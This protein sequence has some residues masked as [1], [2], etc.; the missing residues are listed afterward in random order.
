MCHQ[1]PS[2][3]GLMLWKTARDASAKAAKSRHERKR[4]SCDMPHLSHSALQFNLFAAIQLSATKIPSDS[5]DQ[6]RQKSGMHWV[7]R[8]SRGFDCV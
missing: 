6:H 4:D 1:S 2:Q 3:S 5:L 8:S 7:G